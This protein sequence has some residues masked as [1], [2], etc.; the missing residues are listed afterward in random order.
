MGTA[1]KHPVPDRVARMSKIT[2]AVICH[3]WHP[4][5]LAFSPERQ[6]ARMSKN[7]WRFNRVWH[8]MLYSCTHMT[9]VGVKWLNEA[10]CEQHFRL[11]FVEISHDA[12]VRTLRGLSVE[13]GLSCCYLCLLFVAMFVWFCLLC[14]QLLTLLGISSA[15]M[16]C[17]YHC[18]MC[19]RHMNY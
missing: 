11:K 4:G 19:V 9:T 18:F 1:I 16:P 14:L 13:S 7:K 2:K 8:K 10:W 12:C 3:F 6:S 5:T 15:V 17:F